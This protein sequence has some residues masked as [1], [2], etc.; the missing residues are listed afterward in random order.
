MASSR[1]NRPERTVHVKNTALT[2]SATVLDQFGLPLW[3]YIP[4]RCILWFKRHWFLFALVATFLF[5]GRWW[6]LAILIFAPLCLVLYMKAMNPSRRLTAVLR[7][8]WLL[9][10]IRRRWRWACEKAFLD[11][12][13]KAPHLL[14][15]IRHR[16]PI[17]HNDRGT[18]LEFLI[19]LQRVGLTVTQIEENRDY[20]VGSLGARKARVIRVDPSTA[21]VIFEFGHR[22]PSNP[23]AAGTPTDHILPRVELDEGV[24][25]ELETSILVVGESGM[26]KSN[27]TWFVLN[28]LNRLR[29]PRRLYVCDPKKVELAELIDSP[30]IECYA[31][32]ITDMDYCIDRFY[33]DMMDTFYRMK[34]KKLRRAP[35]GPEWP[36]HI[37]IVDELLLCDQ[38]RKGVDSNLAKV[39]TAGRAAGFFVIADSQLGQ[40]DALSRIRDLFPQRICMRV[41]SGDLVNAVLG[42]KS[43][44]RGAKCTEITEKGVGYIFTEFAGSF[45]RFQLPF[46]V[47]VE[48]IAAGQYWEQVSTTKPRR[49]PTTR[50][51]TSQTTKGQ[52]GAA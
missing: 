44:E 30:D 34:A 23:I 15:G 10:R 50:K 52:K 12:G 11:D 47:D 46:M 4:W 13:G 19:R 2:S 17:I 51:K 6:F 3:L 42:P 38:A 31:D 5:L 24:W 32:D 26:G 21:R 43:D 22:Q 49:R 20:L 9:L 18:S 1:R 14:G 41:T 28:E 25:L 7:A 33:N 16:P 35:I 36:L 27:L 37:L 8:S 39:L 29:I 45:A 40:V 48:A